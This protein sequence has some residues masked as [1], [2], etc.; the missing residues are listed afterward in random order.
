MENNSHRIDALRFVGDINN[1]A[2]RMV[3]D[4]VN[5]AQ[6]H[7]S[8]ELFIQISSLGG[9]IEAAFGIYECLRA[10]NMPITTLCAG[11]VQSAAVLFYLAGDTRLVGLYSQFMIHAIGQKLDGLITHAALGPFIKSLSKDIKRYGDIF[12]E[13]TQAGKSVFDVNKCLCGGEAYID[14]AEAFRLGLA[15]APPADHKV[16]QGAIWREVF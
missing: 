11:N 12:K 7:N 10:A 14:A 8:Q 4:W 1:S 3:C 5:K 6:I 13:R 2:E 15:T 16:P 9:K